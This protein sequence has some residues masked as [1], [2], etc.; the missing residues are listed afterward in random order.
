[1]H[2]FVDTMLAEY[3]TSEERERFLAGLTE[4]DTRASERCGR[5]FLGCDAAEQ[6]AMVEALDRETFAAPAPRPRP[7]PDRE[8][9]RGAA[10]SPPGDLRPDT[11]RRPAAP[12][13]AP[14]FRTM[15]ELTLLGYYTSEPGATAELRHERVPGRFAGCVPLADVGRAWAV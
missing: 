4:L 1:V 2:R 12:P 3:Y 6:R 10:G 7:N 14:F 9:Q 5:P 11:A 13:P 8:T 15:K